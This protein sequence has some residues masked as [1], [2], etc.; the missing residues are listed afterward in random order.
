MTQTN[1]VDSSRTECN[2]GECVRITTTCIDG[3]CNEVRVVIPE[4][5]VDTEPPREPRRARRARS[6]GSD[7]TDEGDDESETDSESEG[8]LCNVKAINFAIIF[9]GVDITLFFG[10]MCLIMFIVFIIG[11]IRIKNKK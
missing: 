10:I 2:D 3:D 7:T 5:E 1:I 9:N 6:A 4:S 11:V 8:E